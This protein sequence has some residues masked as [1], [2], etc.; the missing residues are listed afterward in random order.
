MGTFLLTALLSRV[1]TR[2]VFLDYGPASERQ[3]NSIRSLLPDKPTWRRHPSSRVTGCASNIAGC[4]LIGAGADGPAVRFPSGQCH[5]HKVPGRVKTV[6]FGFGACE[7]GDGQRGLSFDF[8]PCFE[9]LIKTHD[10]FLADGCCP[11]RLCST[12]ID[13]A[14]FFFPC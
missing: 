4:R 9:G 1:F 6:T 14:R 2:H 3:P 13:Y 5:H 7:G 8:E 12:V 10:P 11:Q